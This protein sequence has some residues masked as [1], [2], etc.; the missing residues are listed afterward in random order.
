MQTKLNNYS[1]FF[2]RLLQIID[3]YNIKSINSFA[4]DYLKYDS[5]EKIN[6]LK[7]KNKLPSIKIIEDIS[8]TFENINIDWLVTGR[9][10][11]LR[12]SETKE[13]DLT[14]SDDT[15]YAISILMD[16]IKEKDRQIKCLLDIIQGMSN[17]D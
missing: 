13:S 11:M 16:T 9:G 2:E 4:K 1:I 6:R 7:D 5:S 10:Q 3:Y 15:Q 14:K 17:R 12:N 8:N